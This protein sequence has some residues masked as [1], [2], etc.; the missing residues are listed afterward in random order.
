MI[1]GGQEAWWATY[2][3]SRYQTTKNSFCAPRGPLVFKTANP[4][5]VHPSSRASSTPRNH[6]VMALAHSSLPSASLPSLL[7]PPDGAGHSRPLG[8]M[9]NKL[10]FQCN[11]FRS[12]GH[13][14]QNFP[15]IHYML[16]WLSC[17]Y[18]VRGCCVISGDISTPH[19]SGPQR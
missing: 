11:H 6:P 3:S 4:K 5:P 7:L 17:C 15:L 1:K 19:L 13:T 9:S 16:K 12:L 8:T 18:L 2:S 14:P 10:T